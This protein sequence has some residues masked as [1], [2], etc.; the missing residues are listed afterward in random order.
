MSL[1]EIIKKL[2]L[3]CTKANRLNKGGS[4]SMTEKKTAVGRK[5]GER[6]TSKPEFHCAVHQQT[7]FGENF[8]V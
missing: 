1:C 7:F 3:P 6:L 8:E 5:L 4:E 2:D